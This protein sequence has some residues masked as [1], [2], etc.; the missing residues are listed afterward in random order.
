MRANTKSQ[1]KNTELKKRRGGKHAPYK[2]T[3]LQDNT[4]IAHLNTAIIGRMGEN[5]VENHL[6]ENDYQVFNQTAD[7]WGID[8]VCFKPKLWK[9]EWKIN[10]IT[11]Q[12]KYHTIAYNTSYGKSLKVNITENYAD[13]IAV[14]IDR[15]F[16]DDYEHIIYYPNEKKGIR[17]VREFSFK[18]KYLESKYKNQNPRR[19]ATNWY[20]LPTPKPQSGWNKL[21]KSRTSCD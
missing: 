9:N 7:T 6:L 17:H 20:K 11:V 19:W 4:K 15:G 13:W 14:P 5:R 2:S 21:I 3:R 10:L 8:L 1:F 16:I 18:E 12:V